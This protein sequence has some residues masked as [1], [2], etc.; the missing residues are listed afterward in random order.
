MQYGCVMLCLAGKSQS[1][2]TNETCVVCYYGDRLASSLQSITF[3]PHY[4]V[5][6]CL[7][8]LCAL[9][10][11]YGVG[12]FMHWLICLFQG[13]IDLYKVAHNYVME[14][15]VDIIKDGGSEFLQLSLEELKKL[16]SSGEISVKMWQVCLKN[17]TIIILNLNLKR[18]SWVLSL[19]CQSWV[20]SYVPP[21]PATVDPIY[22]FPFLILK[23]FGNYQAG[24]RTWAHSIV[25]K[26]KMLSPFPHRIDIN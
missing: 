26:I 17:F 24:K 6:N 2:G 14:N 19:G 10:V 8:D 20:K 18:Y 3:S 13:C 1:H 21:R 22:V 25:I 4:K 12:W 11:K 16:L 5:T 9:L 15:F 7:A 23:L